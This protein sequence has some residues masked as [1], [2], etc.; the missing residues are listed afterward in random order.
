MYTFTI[1]RPTIGTKMQPD[2]SVSKATRYGLNNRGS[3]PS[4]GND[5]SLFVPRPDRLWDPPIL[6][7][8]GSVN[9]SLGCKAFKLEAVFS[10]P[11]NVEVNTWSFASTPPY[12]FMRLWIGAAVIQDVNVRTGFSWLGMGFKC[13]LL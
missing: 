4:R 6:Q 7:S 2:I 10:S 9:S 13:R 3:I 8:R 1:I 11:C 5:I 12:L